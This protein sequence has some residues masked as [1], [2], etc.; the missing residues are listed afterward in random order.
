M[1]PAGPG[2][3]A[4]AAAAADS[5]SDAGEGTCLVA[6][7]PLG[8]RA[9]FGGSFSWAADRFWLASLPSF[10]GDGALRAGLP[11]ALP[12]GE[13]AAPGLVGRSGLDDAGLAA[14]KETSRT[15]CP[16]L[17][18]VGLVAPL[19]SSPSSKAAVRSALRFAGDLFGDA[20]DLPDAS[21]TPRGCSWGLGDDPRA[22][23]S[24]R[25]KEPLS[26]LLEDAGFNLVVSCWSRAGDG[27]TLPRR[28][29]NALVALAAAEEA[30][31]E[32][33]CPPLSCSLARGGADFNLDLALDCLVDAGMS[34][35]SGR[36]AAGLGAEFSFRA[37]F[38]FAFQLFERGLAV[39]ATFDCRRGAASMLGRA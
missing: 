28:C 32:R 18:W 13:T 12:V 39:A 37:F 33:L 24:R 16:E 15:P 34:P 26:S 17:P 31:D 36:L 10:L 2:A 22:A 29:E 27:E 1:S 5:F 30:E 25:A 38:F 23:A 8:E 21:R 6:P 3:A 19:S 7:L 35:P 14:R 4:A 20:N 9:L 11:E